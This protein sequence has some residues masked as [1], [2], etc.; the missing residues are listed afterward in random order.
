[1]SQEFHANN[2]GPQKSRC[3]K[4]AS[5]VSFTCSSRAGYSLSDMFSMC[6]SMKGFMS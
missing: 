4:T 1:M 3:F 2:T 6:P 5:A